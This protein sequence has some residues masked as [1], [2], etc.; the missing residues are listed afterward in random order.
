MSSFLHT[1]L[2][3]KFTIYSGHKNEITQIK[4]NPLRTR[5]ASCAGD[6]TTRIWNISD[7]S[8]SH[9]SD[10]MLGLLESEHVIILDGH[11]YPISSIAWCPLMI[12]GVD[13]IATLVTR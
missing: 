7:L 2:F 8:G 12:A 13:I 1:G 10:S 3:A 11:N 9:S 5:L 6:L 4:C